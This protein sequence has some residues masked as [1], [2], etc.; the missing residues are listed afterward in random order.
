MWALKVELD[1]IFAE[2]LDARFARHQAL[3]ERTRQWVAEAGFT[4]LS[5]ADYHSP[6]LSNIANTLEVSVSDVNTFL[7]ERGM[8]ISNGYDSLQNI[9]LELPI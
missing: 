1:H 5:E 7:K 4:M 9:S 2:G 3:A 6:T 8:N